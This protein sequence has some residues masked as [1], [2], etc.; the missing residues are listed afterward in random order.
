MLHSTYL[1]AGSWHCMSD[2]CSVIIYISS[3]CTFWP[4]FGMHPIGS[5]AAVPVWRSPRA[6]A[7]ASGRAAWDVSSALRGHVAC[8]RRRSPVSASPSESR[9]RSAP[10]ARR[11]RRHDRRLLVRW[12]RHVGTP[13][14]ARRV[15]RLAR[16]R[17][18]RQILHDQPTWRGGR[19]ER[20]APQVVA[21]A[22][23]DLGGQTVSGRCL[24]SQIARSEHRRVLARRRRRRVRAWRGR[25]FDGSGVLL[26]RGRGHRSLLVPWR[27]AWRHVLVGWALTRGRFGVKR[28]ELARRCGREGRGRQA[29]RGRCGYVLSARAEAR[30]PARER[31][32]LREAL[33]RRLRHVDT[34]A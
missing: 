23:I 16:R 7:Q 14:P 9:T 1:G 25:R 32:L 34:W 6:G 19:H 10:R 2:H 30:Q 27:G 13:I 17:R 29:G 8:S 18:A 26:P 31:F 15:V 12:R 3:F 4:R 21:A 24:D 20:A 28:T 11:T 22:G 5:R 33:Q